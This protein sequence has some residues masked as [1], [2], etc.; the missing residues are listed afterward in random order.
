MTSARIQEIIVEILSDGNTHSV[1][2]IKN[3]LSQFGND[4]TE[5]QFAGSINTLLRNKTICKLDRGVYTMNVNKDNKR[6]CFVVSPIGEEGSEI[7]ANADKLYKYIIKPVCDACNIEAERIDKRN[8]A[9]SISQSIIESLETYDLVIADITGHNPNVFYEMGYRARTKKPMIHLRKKGENLPFDISTIRA[10]EYDLTDLDS[11]EEVKDRLIKT[12]DTF[13]FSDDNDVL[14][15]E[16]VA[17]N[18]SSSIMSVLY[19]ILD[20]MQE[21]KKDVKSFSTETISTVVKSMQ[22]AQPQVSSDTALQMQLLNGFMQDPEGFVKLIEVSN[23]IN[24]NG[25]K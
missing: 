22:S 4:Y 6:K 18:L 2:E 21:L 23:K 20:T 19:Q 7:R 24:N 25:R 1:Q 13:T 9:N 16:D 8:D 12:I 17:D 5:G 15:Q 3:K 14:E 10:L 11:V